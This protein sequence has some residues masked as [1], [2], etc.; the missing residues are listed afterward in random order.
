M[1]D[2]HVEPKITYFFPIDRQYSVAGYRFPEDKPGK[3]VLFLEVDGEFTTI[4]SVK[5]TLKDI[6]RKYFSLSSKEPYE[7]ITTSGVIIDHKLNDW[8]GYDFVLNLADFKVAS[9]DA[10]YRGEIS[11]Y[12]TQF[13]SHDVIRNG[14]VTCTIYKNFEN[15]ERNYRFT[16]L[17]TEDIEEEKVRKE[18]KRV[19]Q[20]NYEYD[21]KKTILDVIVDFMKTIPLNL[22]LD[23][24]AWALL[25]KEEL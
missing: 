7:L 5:H 19:D 18:I 24:W 14:K 8:K 12:D 17:L 2:T 6:L 3:R 15:G 21:E 11:I 13:R 9:N 23:P 25:E 10:F 16:G 1:A 22:E 4:Y 20:N